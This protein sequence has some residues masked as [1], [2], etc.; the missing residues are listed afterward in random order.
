MVIKEQADL[1]CLQQYKIIGHILVIIF[2]NFDLLVSTIFLEALT[3][4]N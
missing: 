2:Y 1:S 4:K 3:F